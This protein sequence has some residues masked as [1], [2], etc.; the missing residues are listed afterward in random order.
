ML[1]APDSSLKLFLYRNQRI[2]FFNKASDCWVRRKSKNPTTFDMKLY[3]TVVDGC[4]IYIWKL[5]VS[6]LVNQPLFILF[7][8]FIVAKLLTV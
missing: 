1:M 6:G 3:A 7:Q 2:S 5:N 4:K 8:S